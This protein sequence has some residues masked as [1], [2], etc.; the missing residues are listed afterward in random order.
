MKPAVSIIMPVYNKAAYLR[1]SLDSVLNQDFHDY[2]LIIINDGSTDNSI[3]I[4]NEYAE[5]D[6]RF[7]VY[8]V[9]NGGVSRARNIG[10][11][12]A[13]GKWIQFLDGDDTICKEYLSKCVPL[14]EKNNADIVFSDFDMIDQNRNSIKHVSCTCSGLI[15]SDEF[16]HIFIDYQYKN[17]FFGFIS[18]KLIRKDLITEN[19]AGFNEKITLAEDLDFFIQLYRHIN[20]VYLWKGCSFH[21]LQTDTNYSVNSEVDYLVQLGI[22]MRI[23]DWFKIIDPVNI[24]DVIKQKIGDYVYAYLFDE[25]EKGNDIVYVRRILNSEFEDITDILDPDFYKGFKKRIIKAVKEKNSN[26]VMKLFRFRTVVRTAYRKVK[27]G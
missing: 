4:I 22:Q 20:S 21:Y 17:G 5:K 8:S 7:M 18:N 9:E 27:H 12:Y 15:H 25:N 2:E 24:P 23:Y 1:N 16:P 19:N 11:S 13:E 6:N 10:L 26:T 14:A 3:E